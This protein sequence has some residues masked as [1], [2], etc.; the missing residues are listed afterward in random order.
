MAF[1]ENKKN[2]NSIYSCI[3]LLPESRKY[4]RDVSGDIEID[5]GYR[6][7][8]SYLESVQ[9]GDIVRQ[10]VRIRQLYEDFGADYIVL[11]TRNA[12][13]KMPLNI[14][15]YYVIIAEKVWKAERPIRAEGC[16]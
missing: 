6:R 16:N 9:G 14:E 5:S 2:D 15:I 8:V 12:G 1:V 7:I 11:D 3:R 10:A 4:S 13:R